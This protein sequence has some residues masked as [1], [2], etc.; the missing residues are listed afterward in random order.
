MLSDFRS[1]SGR[2]R[3]FFEADP[4]EISPALAIFSPYS[5]MYETV[6]AGGRFRPCATGLSAA[7]CYDESATDSSPI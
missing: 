5:S 1:V 2:P 3:S 6:P 4:A 7:D